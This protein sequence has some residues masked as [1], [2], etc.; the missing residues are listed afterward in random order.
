M[1]SL[2]H[3]IASDARGMPFMDLPSINT[4]HGSFSLESGPNETM[5]RHWL[6][7]IISEEPVGG[8]PAASGLI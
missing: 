3:S 1:A 4:G 2:V 7:R 6:I 5:G 8:G